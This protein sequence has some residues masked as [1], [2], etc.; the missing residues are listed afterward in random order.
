VGSRVTDP[1]LIAATTLGDLLED[2]GRRFG[3]AEAV[4]FEDGER[5]SFA[6]L[7][8]QA[9]RRA[10]QLRALG[11]GRGDTVGILMPNALDYLTSVFGAATLG[12]IPIPVNTRFAA[13][14]LAHVL[15]Q[16]DVRVLLT[17]RDGGHTELAREALADAPGVRHVVCLD[18]PPPAGML[19]RDALEAGEAQVGEDGL[20][21]LRTRLSVADPALIMFTSGTTARP[22]GCVLTH[23]GLTRHVRSIARERFVLVEGDR[24]W[25]PLPF[26]HMSTWLPLGACLVAGAT[27]LPM[28]RFDPAVALRQ[29]ERERCTFA[30]PCFEAVA[31]ALT[32]HP[33]YATTD[34]SRITRTVNVGLPA[35]LR[36]MQ[37]QMPWAVQ[38]SSYGMTE[39]T[40]VVTYNAPDDP[41]DRRIEAVGRPLPGMEARIVDPETGAELPP[42]ERGEIVYRG[43]ARFAGYHRDPEATAAAIDADGWMHSGDLCSMDAGGFISYHGRLKDMLKV[44]GE[45]VAAAEVEG[46][47][48]EHPAVKAVHVVAAPDAR[49]DEVAAAYVELHDGAAATAEELIAACV[50][51]LA[52]FK[53]PRYVRFV[54]AWPMSGTKVRKAELRA[55]IAAE[56]AERG[57]TEA[58]ELAALR[59][60]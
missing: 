2:A 47:L 58:P 7:A 22:K 21:V 31:G 11:V 13:E 32:A 3:D 17:A 46:V 60:A 6:E 18:G 51:R 12:A 42:G 45:N 25:D 41:E 14:E 35:R 54:T 59:S 9:R 39:A 10:R 8:A 56:L 27:F 48:I 1:P 19:G 43:Y 16:G 5:T 28:R 24:L 38:L 34:L 52:K 4:V 40:G 33:A 20:A 57:I 15:R 26:F 29:L 55:W 53:V 50:G 36:A 30:Y 37:E 23:E 49:Y 44:G